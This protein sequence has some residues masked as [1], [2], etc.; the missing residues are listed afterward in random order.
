[1]SFIFDFINNSHTMLVLQLAGSILLFIFGLHTFHS[2]PHAYRTNPMEKMHALP[3]IPITK[4]KMFYN[5][6]TG[7]ALAISNPLIVLLFVALFA[8]MSF[9]LPELTCYE[10]VTGYAAIW[11]GALVWWFI[12]TT[13]VNKLRKQFDVRGIWI[14]NRIIG[15]IVMLLGILGVIY[16]LIGMKA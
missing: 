14:L 3:T 15:S 11:G 4:G 1:M 12:I 6:A 16:T 7:F 13:L 8:R 2:N 9:V 5:S 10:R